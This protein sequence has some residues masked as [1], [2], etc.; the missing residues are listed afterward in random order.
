[1][2]FCT[3][4]KYQQNSKQFAPIR[5]YITPHVASSLGVQLGSAAKHSYV[6]A[7]DWK[8]QPLVMKLP[9]P[10]SQWRANT[11]YETTTN[12]SFRGTVPTVSHCLHGGAEFFCKLRRETHL[13][14]QSMYQELYQDQKAGVP[15]AARIRDLGVPPFSN[16]LGSKREGRP[17]SDRPIGHLDRPIGHLDRPMG[18]LERPHFTKGSLVRTTLSLLCEAKGLA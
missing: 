1:M 13:V 18:H 6:C 12:A 15:C 14:D 2:L 9:S 3:S 17:G 4:K 11:H 16:H 5:L 10:Y 8:I 7:N